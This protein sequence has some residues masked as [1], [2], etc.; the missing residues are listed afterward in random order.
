MTHSRKV[1]QMAS[2]VVSLAAASGAPPRKQ[3]ARTGQ[4]SFVLRFA[5]LLLSYTSQIHILQT[6]AR[7][8]SS[9]ELVLRGVRA[10]GREAEQR[11]SRASSTTSSS[12]D[13]NRG[14]TN[15]IETLSRRG[16]G[17]SAPRPSLFEFREVRL[18][19]LANNGT[20]AVKENGKPLIT[21]VDFI[22]TLAYHHEGCE[23]ESDGRAGE[24][25]LECG[26]VNND[27]CCID[28]KEGGA[29]GGKGNKTKDENGGTSSCSSLTDTA[30]P[31]S[32]SLS[33]AST[34]TSSTVAGGSP[35][36]VL[37]GDDGTAT[38]PDEDA[39][40][41]VSEAEDHAT[42][43]LP[44]EQDTR[45]PEG[46]EVT[47]RASR[48]ASSDDEI[49]ASS[50]KSMI[51][52]VKEV[53]SSKYFSETGKTSIYDPE[54]Q[55][56]LTKNQE[57]AYPLLEKNGAILKI[58]QRLQNCPKKK[59]DTQRLWEHLQLN[60]AGKDGRIPPQRVA[61]IKLRPKNAPL[62]CHLEVGQDNG[63][64]GAGGGRRRM[65]TSTSAMNREEDGQGPQD[66]RTPNVDGYGDIEQAFADIMDHEQH[67]EV[68][69]A[70]ELADEDRREQE[71]ERRATTVGID[72]H[73]GTSSAKPIIDEHPPRSKRRSPPM[74]K[75][76]ALYAAN[77][78]AVVGLRAE[79]SLH[80][81]AGLNQTTTT[82]ASRHQLPVVTNGNPSLSSSTQAIVDAADSSAGRAT[83]TA[84]SARD[85][86]ETNINSIVSP[87]S[88]DSY[89]ASGRWRS[90]CNTRPFQR[91]RASGGAAPAFAVKL[92]DNRARTLSRSNNKASSTLTSTIS[93]AAGVLGV[94]VSGVPVSVVPPPLSSSTAV[95]GGIHVL[96]KMMKKLA[97]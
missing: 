12:T 18:Q 88:P 23:V 57:K 61:V 20:P 65:A 46:T 75:L 82:S 16:R 48:S 29:D 58:P 25:V 3:R 9:S 39:S 72:E 17:A 96:Q 66:S 30:R 2:D 24:V 7:A 14:R 73:H 36:S 54:V 68:F 53:K 85:V 80:L 81:H 32:Y 95:G 8:S 42:V 27:R 77:R 59:K 64:P 13:Q 45:K 63:L 76:T 44:V 22:Q 35:P 79:V 40:Q 51:T 60:L 71:D 41:A 15:R 91:P 62:S 55:R 90:H 69:R 6:A 83:S 11:V 84:S 10:Q 74:R 38:S 21:R 5:V 89:T 43:R 4:L 87:N 50:S 78:L 49:M 93:G 37:L 33:E 56:R 67:A 31:R 86:G 52:N 94:P 70:E 92:H 1:D 34:A 47:N 97:I 28:I 26:R 19:P